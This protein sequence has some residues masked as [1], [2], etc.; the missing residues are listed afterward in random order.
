MLVIFSRLSVKRPV[1]HIEKGTEKGKI[2]IVCALY[3]QYAN[4]NLPL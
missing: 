4:I 3:A 1:I 2:N